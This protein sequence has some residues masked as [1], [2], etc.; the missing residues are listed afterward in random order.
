MQSSDLNAMILRTTGSGLVIGIAVTVFEAFFGITRFLY[1]WIFALSGGIP[2]LA[3]AVFVWRYPRFKGNHYVVTMGLLAT[4]I[5]IYYFA[6]DWVLFFLALF[7]QAMVSLYQN[8]PL[9]WI[10]VSTQMALFTV[11]FMVDPRFIATM[12]RLNGKMGYGSILGDIYACLIIGGVFFDFLTSYIVR[13]ARRLESGERLH[14]ILDS[15][16]EAV[17]GMNEKGEI[18]KW[19]PQAATIF[20]WSKEEVIGEN[21]FDLIIPKEHRH[22]LEHGLAS[23][24][25]SGNDNSF[26]S[27]TDIAARNREGRE[28][29]VEVVI[30]AVRIENGRFDVVAFIEDISEQK[31]Y[32][33]ELVALASFDGLTSLLN[34]REFQIRLQQEVE[35]SIRYKRPLS[36]LLVDVDHFKRINDTYGHLAGD[37]VLKTIGQIL[38]EVCRKCDVAARYGGEEFSL[39]LPEVEVAQAVRVAERLRQSVE[40]HRYFV[41]DEPFSVTVSIGVSDLNKVINDGSALIES[42]DKALYVAKGNGRNRVEVATSKSIL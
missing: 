22:T 3:T 28:L 17:I 1:I 2:L 4:S 6:G 27:R 37:T 7:A 33:E 21:L 23:F 31:R 26:R 10:A 40:G 30:V 41:N 38:G 42:A 13:M 11:I 15:A 25:S 29:P 18:H 32:E 14:L 9:L 20:G 39:L 36:L 12:P 19:N 8:R 16:M 35:R 34:H 5:S 24:L